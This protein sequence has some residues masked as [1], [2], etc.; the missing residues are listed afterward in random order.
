MTREQEKIAVA[1]LRKMSTWHLQ[2][3]GSVHA[4]DEV[5]LWRLA[6]RELARRKAKPSKP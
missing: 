3:M 2:L 4:P 5:G 1:K 6:L